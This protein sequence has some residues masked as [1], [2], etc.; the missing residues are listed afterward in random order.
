[1]KLPVPVSQALAALLILASSSSHAE[2]SLTPQHASI[3]GAGEQLVIWDAQEADAGRWVDARTFWLNA[4]SRARGKF[5]GETSD[6]PAYRDVKE[7][8]TLLIQTTQGQCLM[9]FFH[10]RWRR[11]QDVQRWNPE[12][13]RIGGCPFVFD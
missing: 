7:H 8:D 13:N 2:R 11:A 12:L 4:A 3:S 6:Y 9:Y 10:S 5:W 1:M